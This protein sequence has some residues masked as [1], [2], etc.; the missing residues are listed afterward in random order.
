MKKSKLSH[1]LWVFALLGIVFAALGSP[2]AVT[3]QGIPPVDP[4]GPPPDTGNEAPP[5][6]PITGGE[7]VTAEEVPPLS[8][9]KLV[10]V[11]VALFAIMIVA[12]LVTDGFLNKVD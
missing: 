4:T 8:G 7:P 11:L 5:L 6:I 1:I 2:T 10:A 3:A 9:G 12:L